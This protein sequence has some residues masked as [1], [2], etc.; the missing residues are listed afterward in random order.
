MRLGI[1]KIENYGCLMLYELLNR[2]TESYSDSWL[3]K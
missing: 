3:F 2:V 1:N